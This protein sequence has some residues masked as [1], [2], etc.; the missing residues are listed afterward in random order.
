MKIG[1]MRGIE[2]L[3]TSCRKSGGLA[4]LNYFMYLW[5]T[6]VDR[7]FT[8]FIIFF[9][10]VEYFIGLLFSASPLSYS[11]NINRSENKNANVKIKMCLFIKKKRAYFVHFF[12]VQERTLP[13]WKNSSNSNT[14]HPPHFA[15]KL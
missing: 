3:F 11:I 1:S 10:S 6:S 14:Q 13:V 7:K 8:S 15:H 2:L 12:H 5:H 4:N 9:A